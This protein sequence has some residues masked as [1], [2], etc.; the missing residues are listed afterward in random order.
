VV[1]Y[2]LR[3]TW[4][5]ADWMDMAGWAVLALLLSLSWVVPWY[6]MLLLPLAA[7]SRDRRLRRATLAITAVLVDTSLPGT[8]LLLGDHIRWY[9]DHTKLGKKHAG[10]IQRYLK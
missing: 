10:E 9:P 8:A 3:R 6:V 2:L 7:L 5:G 4:R 1:V